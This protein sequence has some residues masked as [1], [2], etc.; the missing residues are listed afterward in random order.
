MDINKSDLGYA[1]YNANLG[2]DDTRLDYSGKGMYGKTCFGIVGTLENLLLFAVEIA[3]QVE[4]AEQTGED[5][6]LDDF[7]CRIHEVSTDS[8]GRSQIFYWPYVHV[9]E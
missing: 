4:A 9:T 3:R 7:L 1:L 2:E 5:H 6:P 8:M